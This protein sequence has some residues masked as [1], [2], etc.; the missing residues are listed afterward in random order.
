MTT[1]RKDA[2]GLNTSRIPPPSY[3]AS[4]IQ[5][6]SKKLPI[7]KNETDAIA[8]YDTV[9]KVLMAKWLIVLMF[10]GYGIPATLAL[11]A[12]WKVGGF[13]LDPWVLTATIVSMT[14]TV[15]YMMRNVLTVI[16][17]TD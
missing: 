6:T 5:D 12:G 13:Y 9:E 4:E 8:T 2:L 11:L 3:D 14:S 1:G 7:P 17:P 10:L 15:T 16:F